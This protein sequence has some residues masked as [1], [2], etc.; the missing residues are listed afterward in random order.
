MAS[1]LQMEKN[2]LGH[3]VSLVGKVGG[4]IEMLMRSLPRGLKYGAER[5]ESGKPMVDEPE[6]QLGV[7]HI[8][9]DSMACLAALEAQASIEHL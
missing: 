4:A 9:C 2:Y 1:A 5:G 8:G 6:D 7:F 3:S